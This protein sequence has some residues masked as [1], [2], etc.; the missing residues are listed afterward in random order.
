MS[1]MEGRRGLIGYKMCVTAEETSLGW[2]V[3]HHI[4]PLIAAIRI[5]NTITSENSTQPKEFK[6]QD[7]EERLNNWRGKAMYGQY[8]RQIDDKDKS[9]TW[10]WLRK[11]N[12]KG[13]TEALICSAPER[14]LRT[15][16]MKFHIDKTGESP[17]CKMCRVENETVS[18]IASECKRKIKTG[19]TMYAG[20]FTG[21]YVRNMAFKEHNS[22]TSMSQ[23]ELSRTKGTRFCGILQSNVIPTLKLDD[24]K[25]LL[26]I[27]P[28]RKFRL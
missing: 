20:I 5:S 7:N 13:C 10:K 6:Q 8:V 24:Q 19:M 17:L 27:K 23:V 26:L 12:L 9:N 11:S 14:G 28:R 18:Y 16:Y 3:K 15:N 2:Y 21:D 25:L 22:A 1:R 4:E